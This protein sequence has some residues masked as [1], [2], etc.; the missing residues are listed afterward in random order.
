MKMAAMTLQ[1]PKPRIQLVL[2]FDGTIT[3]E[4]T[5][6]VIGGRCITKARELAANG[7]SLDQLP[8]NMRYY[9]DLYFQQYKDW[10][11][12]AASM[13]VERRTIDEE[14]SYLSQSRQVEL[15]SFLRVRSAV[16]GVSGGIGDLEH[17]TG[18]RNKTMMVEGCEAV[19]TGEIKI[20]DP[21]AL[22]SL[23]AK[24]GDGS[25][26]WGIV[27]VSWS[28]RFILGALL[29]GGLIDQ[30]NEDDFSKN[31]KANELLAPLATTG[32]H[33]ANVICSAMDKRDALGRLLADWNIND[34][35]EQSAAITIYVGD[36]STDIGCL[37]H[38]SIGCY[39][40]E[41]STKDHVVQTLN[42]LGVNCMLLS[43]LESI[44]EARNKD[45]QQRTI[46]LI[47]GFEEL[48][49]WLSR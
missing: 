23:I 37:G 26:R 31:I 5:T 21:K 42:R 46:Y 45:E 33:G 38:S 43:K 25:N 30:G 48:D 18:L 39:F 19:R 6:A 40:C 14:A 47:Q 4:D 8:N 11:D 27:S 2:D 49:D 7:L 24:A 32:D 12:S 29:E 13:P 22:K 1:K 15:D 9:S 10:K 3:T 16:L 36:S 17:D 35:A 41:D 34:R 44:T 28:R 20:R